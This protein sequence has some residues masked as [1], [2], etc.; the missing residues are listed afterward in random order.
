MRAAM[1]APTPRPASAGNLAPFVSNLGVIHARP[2]DG[3]CGNNDCR[4]PGPQPAELCLDDCDGRGARSGI[5]QADQATALINLAASC[6][7]G[8]LRAGH[9]NRRQDGDGQ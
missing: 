8:E 6:A 2:G 3:G 1:S 7:A 9:G 4:R 5:E